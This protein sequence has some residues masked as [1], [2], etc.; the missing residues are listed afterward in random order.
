MKNRQ[1][2]DGVARPRDQTG[3]ERRLFMYYVYNAQK[4][5]MMGRLSEKILDGNLGAVMA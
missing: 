4:M 1:T 3:A 5:C 2:H